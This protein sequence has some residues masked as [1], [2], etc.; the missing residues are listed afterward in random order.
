MKA[1]GHVSRKEKEINT[2]SDDEDME[3]AQGKKKKGLF[4]HLLSFVNPTMQ[5]RVGWAEG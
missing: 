4:C 1:T 2:E 5:L 3:E